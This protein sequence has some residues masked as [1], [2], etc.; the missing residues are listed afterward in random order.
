MECFMDL[1][2]MYLGG[3]TIP[4]GW[5]NNTKYMTESAKRKLELGMGDPMAA[6]PLVE[7]LTCESWIGL[8]D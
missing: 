1:R 7:T 4:L 8:V 2:Y 6:H 3:D 5:E